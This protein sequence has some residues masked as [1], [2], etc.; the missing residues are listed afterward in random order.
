MQSE[1]VITFGTFPL[2]LKQSHKC[3]KTTEIDCEDG[4]VE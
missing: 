4:V 1:F 2:R 3:Y